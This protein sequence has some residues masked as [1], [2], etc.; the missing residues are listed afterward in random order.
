MHQP[1]DKPDVVPGEPEALAQALTRLAWAIN[2]ALDQ[3]LADGTI[4]RAGIVAKRWKVTSFQY[5]E[6]GPTNIQSQLEDVV[7][8]NWASAAGAL[9]GQ[10]ASTP[11]YAAV[12]SLYDAATGEVPAP[13]V[14]NF[15]RV[16]LHRRSA[17]ATLT[18]ADVQNFVDAFV[19]E[20]KGE[21]ILC[22]VDVALDG[23]VLAP[24]TVQFQ[25]PIAVTLRQTEARD[26]EYV[27]D[28]FRIGGGPAW[29]GPTTA[30][31]TFS[32]WTKYALGAQQAV[33]RV[34][35][36]LRLFAPMSVRAVSY[37]L[38]AD[39]SSS[40]IPSGA[41]FFQGAAEV[42]ASRFR[43]TPDAAPVLAE[44]WGKL[45]PQ[46]P[47]DLYALQPRRV[48]PLGLA[49]QRYCDALLRFG[50]IEQ[51]LASAVMG[52]E[53]LLVKA[54]EKEL[55]GLR[56]S[57]RL[58]KILSSLGYDPSKVRKQV[59]DGYK[60]RSTFVHGHEVTGKEKRRLERDH[61]GLEGLLNTLL[62]QLR[63]ALV[64]LIVLKEDKETFIKRVDAA[65]TDRNA[66]K[67][68]DELVRARAGELGRQ[69]LL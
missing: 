44:F 24:D 30:F 13:T 38:T 37:T 19:R 49:Y 67:R 56:L 43:L 14:E 39:G 63:L 12:V 46:L 22:Q 31:L 28:P 64:L 48:T 34:L 50:V 68:L 8:P 3:G 16:I 10:L 36:A 29:Q 33:P 40:R 55:L 52:L 4:P 26:Y 9:A 25:S 6:N 35:A 54:D 21:P 65:F 15:I 2:S 59:K 41:T 51:R 18:A 60:V 53:G 20:V 57:M 7:F 27:A 17:G 47:E 5:A 42:S 1:P 11:E 23:I 32:L 58:A 62:E 45:Y 61:G 66:D 69:V